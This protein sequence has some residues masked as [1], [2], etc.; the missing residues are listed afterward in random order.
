MARALPETLVRQCEGRYES[1]SKERLVKA[2]RT[3]NAYLHS[4]RGDPF[5]DFEDKS[6]LQAVSVS[7]IEPTDESE[8]SLA[9]KIWR[10]KRREGPQ[11]LW[12][13][14]KVVL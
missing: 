4:T 12:K 8:S 6:L 7:L 14:P 3:H 11:Y 5:Q 10:I 2:S 1:R 9:S 13:R